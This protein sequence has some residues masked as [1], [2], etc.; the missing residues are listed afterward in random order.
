[1]SMYNWIPPTQGKC[2]T[3]ALIIIIII[4]ILYIYHINSYDIIYIIFNLSN[5]D[6]SVRTLKRS[7][8]PKFKTWNCI[9][10]CYL[11][12]FQILTHLDFIRTRYDIFNHFIIVKY[13]IISHTKST[14]QYIYFRALQSTCLSGLT[15]LIWLDIKSYQYD[16]FP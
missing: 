10:L 1:M 4:L 16:L 3:F 5:T 15:Y 13:L 7:N 11:H 2:L 6:I 8:L 9:S 12:Y 14:N